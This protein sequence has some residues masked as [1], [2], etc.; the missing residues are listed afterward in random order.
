MEETWR[1]YRFTT[2]DGTSLY[3]VTPMAELLSTNTKMAMPGAKVLADAD[4][5]SRAGAEGVRL[6]CCESFVPGAGLGKRVH[7]R[8]TMVRNTYHH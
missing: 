7:A 2:A 1:Y 3:C 8:R 5:V 4:D 6:V